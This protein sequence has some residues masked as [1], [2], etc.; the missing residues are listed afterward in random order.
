MT[1]WW[2]VTAAAASLVAAPTAVIAAVV[3][4]RA[5][6]KTTTL[7][8]DLAEGGELKRWQQNELKAMAARFLAASHVH[9]KSVEKLFEH[10]E[11]RTTDDVEAAL[12]ELRELELLR[13]QLWLVRGALVTNAVDDLYLRHVDA[14]TYYGQLPIRRPPNN[15]IVAMIAAEYELVLAA[16]SE[17]G[18][19]PVEPPT[20]DTDG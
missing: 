19:H 4:A 12:S 18:T 7:A 8:A 10:P 6:N 15:L 1:D 5:S 9:R 20:T 16:R 14:T 3:A 2:S 13:E 11:R 17:L